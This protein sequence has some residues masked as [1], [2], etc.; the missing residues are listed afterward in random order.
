MVEILQIREQFWNTEQLISYP[1]RAVNKCCIS[2]ALFEQWARNFWKN[3]KKI[4]LSKYYLNQ[5]V[6]KRCIP[7]TPQ[8]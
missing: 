6:N 5:A 1:R 8:P 7:E 4:N 3:F 2:V